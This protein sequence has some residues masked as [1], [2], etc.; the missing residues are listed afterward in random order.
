VFAEF[1]SNLRRERQKEGMAK[2]KEA[3]T[4]KVRRPSIDVQ[5]VARMRKEGL[6]AKGDSQG[7]GDWKGIGLS[8]ASGRVAVMMAII[9][10]VVNMQHFSKKYSEPLFVPDI[11]GS[12]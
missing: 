7:V 10:P 9:T 3:G 2:S 8:G 1:E 5:K 11:T 12:L 4:Y 6:G